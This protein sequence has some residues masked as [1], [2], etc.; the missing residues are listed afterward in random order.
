MPRDWP[1]L[2]NPVSFLFENNESKSL[3][4]SWCPS[5]GLLTPCDSFL[6]VLLPSYSMSSFGARIDPI[7][8]KNTTCREEKINNRNTLRDVIDERISR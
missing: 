7:M 5:P 4:Y 1:D 2:Q 3:K 6:T 8:Q